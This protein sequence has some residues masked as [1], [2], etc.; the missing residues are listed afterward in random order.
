MTIRRRQVLGVA[1]VPF[2]PP[3]ALIEAAKRDGGFINYTA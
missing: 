2:N 3:D 1:A